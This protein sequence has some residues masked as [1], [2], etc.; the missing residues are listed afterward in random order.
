MNKYSSKKNLISNHFF[1]LLSNFCS[2]ILIF[3]YLFGIHSRFTFYLSDSLYI[4]YFFSGLSGLILLIKNIKKVTYFRIKPI[5]ILLF[6][7]AI[8]I[9]L[10]PD[11]SVFLIERFKAF[12]YFAYSLTIAYAIYLELSQW[13]CRHI[14]F[15][16]FGAMITILLGCSLENYTSFKMISDQFRF[17]AYPHYYTSEIRDILLHGGIRP[18]LFTAEPSH[19]ASS[20]ILFSISWLIISTNRYK[21][22]IF[23]V[24]FVIL[25]F[26]IRSPIMF[27]GLF[28]AFIIYFYFNLSNIKKFFDITK[29]LK[30]I[31]LILILII[32]LYSTLTTALSGRLDFIVKGEDESILLRLVTPIFIAYE[33]IVQYPFFGAGIGGKEA[34]ENITLSVFMNHGINVNRLSKGIGIAH[35]IPNAFWEYWIVFGLFGGLLG[36]LCFNNFAR[37]LSRNN[38]LIFFFLILAYGFA[39]GAI[40]GTW[41]W[42]S[43]FLTI[44]ALDKTEKQVL[45]ERRVQTDFDRHFYRYTTQWPLEPNE[46]ITNPL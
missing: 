41:I 10:S 33:T 7:S 14:I 46:K 9:F 36:L 18:K 39:S 31:F 2:T 26:L 16:F 13:D 15:L 44:M 28:S 22:I 45:K 37:K 17:F 12:I 34:I 20:Y 35:T 32:I 42:A 27:I 5:A 8:S 3:I 4:P 29:P 30:Y 23:L 25:L 6:I 19:L 24:L 1:N 38:K 40:G 11:S 21:F 43:V